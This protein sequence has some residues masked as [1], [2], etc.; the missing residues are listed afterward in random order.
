MNGQRLYVD[1][2]NYEDPEEALRNFAK[3][4]DKKWI[5][6]EKIIGGGTCSNYRDFDIVIHPKKP[7]LFSSLALRVG[8]TSAPSCLKG[9]IMLSTGKIT[10]KWIG[11]DNTNCVI[12]WIAIYAEFS[13]IRN[14]AYSI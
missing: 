9:L 11:V 4:L 14:L 1:P 5:S 2:S 12:Y 7:C 6:L 3:E 8:E 10:I 13:V